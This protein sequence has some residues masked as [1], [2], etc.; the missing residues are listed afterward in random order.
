MGIEKDMKKGIHHSELAAMAGHE[1]AR[2]NLGCI[3]Y[4]SRNMER[5]MK[6]W[7]ISAS[8]GDSDS[9]TAIHQLFKMGCVQNDVYELTLKAHNDSCAEMRSKAREDAEESWRG[10]EPKSYLKK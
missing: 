3:E 2:Y 8:A 10:Q 5:A 4:E 6:H 7:K 1:F 9:M